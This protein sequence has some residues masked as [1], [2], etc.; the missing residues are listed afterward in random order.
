MSATAVKLLIDAQNALI[1]A[2]DD[3]DVAAIETATQQMAQAVEGVRTQDAW[4]DP[5]A[6]E[7]L[8][9]AMKQTQAA[10]IRVNYLSDWTRQKIDRFSEIRGG[11][12]SSKHMIY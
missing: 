10:R 3:G 6:V 12:R 7:D 11:M 8:N 9:H 2:L 5:S 4:H 1:A